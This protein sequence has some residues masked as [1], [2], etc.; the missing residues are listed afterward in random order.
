MNLFLSTTSRNLGQKAHQ[1]FYPERTIIGRMQ[2]ASKTKNFNIQHLQPKTTFSSDLDPSFIGSST[3]G[4]INTSDTFTSMIAPWVSETSF[5]GK[6][7][8][9]SAS[10]KISS[11]KNIFNNA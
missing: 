3:P 11:L 7:F 10:S 4:K 8:L 6:K 9:F 1:N 5:L 2:G